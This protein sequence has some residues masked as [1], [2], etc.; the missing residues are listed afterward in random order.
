MKVAKDGLNKKIEEIDDASL[1]EIEVVDD[2]FV[3]KEVS[4]K[5]LSEKDCVIHNNDKDRKYQILQGFSK[6][7][8]NVLKHYKEKLEVRNKKKNWLVNRFSCLLYFQTLF[9]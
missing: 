2:G 7:L 4:G 1:T 8:W 5:S 6:A 3:S 9:I